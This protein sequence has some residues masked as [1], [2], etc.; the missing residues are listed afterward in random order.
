MELIEVYPMIA[1]VM[2]DIRKIKTKIAY[3][4]LIIIIRIYYITFFINWNKENRRF[5][6]GEWYNYLR[7]E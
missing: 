1:I 3:V 6:Q 2:K 4:K 7:I 5:L